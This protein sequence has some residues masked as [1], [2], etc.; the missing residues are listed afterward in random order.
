VRELLELAH[1]PG[2]TDASL[3]GD[4][5]YATR[6]AHAPF[7]TL[8]K[9]F[10]RVAPTHERIARAFCVRGAALRKRRFARDA[11]ET[12]TEPADSSIVSRPSAGWPMALRSLA[13]VFASTPSLSVRA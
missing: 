1:D 7:E 10:Q 8:G 11:V 4:D 6:T 9:L 5:E 13:S 3:A 2:L 12:V